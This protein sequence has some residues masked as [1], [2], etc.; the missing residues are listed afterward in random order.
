[1]L[2]GRE[3]VD[4]S[5]EQGTYLSEGLMFIHGWRNLIEAAVIKVWEM[6]SSSSTKNT[7]SMILNCF[8]K[9]F[10]KLSWRHEYWHRS[11][12]IISIS[13]FL[14]QRDGF[15]FA[16]VTFVEVEGANTITQ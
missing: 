14:D 15:R 1:M 8:K 9:I 12:I 5:Q 13:S 2:T 16:V 11:P 4:S 10:K 7:L 3:D 6:L